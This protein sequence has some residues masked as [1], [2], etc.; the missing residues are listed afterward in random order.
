MIAS[1][2]SFPLDA[3]AYFDLCFE[4]EG[5]AFSS[6]LHAPVL[7]N[8]VIDTHTALPSNAVRVNAW[9][10]FLEREVVEIVP[11]AQPSAALRVLDALGWKY[12]PVP[13]LPGMI[14]ARV[15]AMIINEAYF[16][17]GDG[18]S[19]RDDIDTAMKLGTNYPFGP[20]EWA[21]KIGLEK[22]GA[23]LQTLSKQDPRYTPAP[24]L[25]QELK[26]QSCR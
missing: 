24:A 5:A 19:S 14:A 13:D 10:G 17:W 9:N 21:G 16:G 15:I 2:E 25:L 23:L 22:I 1:G 20:F 12:K 26:S 3:D 6:I 7:V 4:E 18:I 8:A 11:G